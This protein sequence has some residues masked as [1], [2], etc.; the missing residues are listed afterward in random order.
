MVPPVQVLTVA[1][2]ASSGATTAAPKAATT[3]SAARHTIHTYLEIIKSP[4]CASRSACL[5][6]RH[7]P[8]EPLARVP[9]LGTHY[10]L[11]QGAI[12]YPRDLQF[13]YPQHLVQHPQLTSTYVADLA[14]QSCQLFALVTCKIRLLWYYL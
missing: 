8:A 14:Q 11:V 9:K 5:I 6:Y 3:A 4:L 13:P 1:A 2:S 10:D 7:K 12:R